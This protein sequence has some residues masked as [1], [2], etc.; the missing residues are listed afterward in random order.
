M[1]PRGQGFLEQ[2]EEGVCCRFLE[3]DA[4]SFEGQSVQIWS[5]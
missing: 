1:A 3:G 5:T 2:P 4:G